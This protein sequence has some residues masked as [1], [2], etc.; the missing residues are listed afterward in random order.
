MT[1][2]EILHIVVT[3]GISQL[4]CELLAKYFVYS[5]DAYER[6]VAA[7]ERAKWKLDKATEDA[8]KSSKH[9]KRLQRAK[10]EYG[11]QCALVSR[12]HT[13]PGFL[14]SIFFVMLL[15]ILGTEHKGHVMAIL[16]FPPFKFLSRITARGLDWSVLEDESVLEGMSISHKQG[17]SFLFIYMLS[18]L[19][20]KFFVSKAVG[21]QPPAGADK[22]L[23]TIME[24]PGGKRMIRSFGLDPDDL[25]KQE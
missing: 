24:S 11:E 20:V 9:E 16:P 7:L 18:A 25:Y 10:D 1:A 14:S 6:R 22:G 21:T 12:K 17:T 19:S 23:M 15:R 4:C 8:A 13:A 5:G 2:S 3:V